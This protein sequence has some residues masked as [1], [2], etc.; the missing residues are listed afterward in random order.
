[1]SRIQNFLNELDD[2]ELAFFAKFKL[3]TYMKSTQLKI[4]EILIERNLNESK[5]NQLISEN[6]KSKLN[7]NK[8]RCT[9]CYT[10]KIRKDRVEWTNTS[11]GI[12]FEDETAISDGIKGEA[13]YK[14]EIICNVCGLWIKDPNQEKEKSTL[15][16]II[17]KV[18]NYVS[19]KL[20][21]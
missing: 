8:E 7:D 9:R 16:E 13:T 18:W 11:T 21:N 5:I 12:G 3:M 4:K 17:H 20:H 19:D 14:E 10:N 6:P 1:M 2:Y 15:N